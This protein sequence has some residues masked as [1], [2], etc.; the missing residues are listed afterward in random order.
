MKAIIYAAAGTVLGTLILR[1]ID[2]RKSSSCDGCSR[3]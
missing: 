2:A 1:A 3:R